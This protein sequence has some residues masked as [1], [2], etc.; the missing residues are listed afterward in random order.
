MVEGGASIIANFLHN[1]LVDWIVLTI[2]PVLLGGL[3]IPFSGP[4]A[5]GWE[6]I[7]IDVRGSRF[8]GDDLVLWGPPEAKVR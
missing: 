3:R 8:Y 4:Q 6:P 5:A 7:R 2:A 1:R